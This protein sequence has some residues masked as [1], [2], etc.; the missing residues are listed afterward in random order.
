VCS[1]CRHARN[2]RGPDSRYQR[3]VF[4][5]DGFIGEVSVFASNQ[6][7][8]P[9]LRAHRSS[10]GRTN[11][12]RLRHSERAMTR[13]RQLVY[14]T[15]LSRLGVTMIAAGLVVLLCYLVAPFLP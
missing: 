1:T 9:A 6:V 11:S 13:L 5:R 12:T 8:C 10:Q 4:G 3:R 2:L 15:D 14:T 7:A